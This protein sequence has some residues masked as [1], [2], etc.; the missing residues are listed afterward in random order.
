MM[1]YV[2]GLLLLIA[3]PAMAQ[4]VETPVPFDS[5]G[6]LMALTPE[7]AA[8]LSLGPPAWR[9]VGDYSEARLYSLGAGSYV[10][11]VTRR[12]G[13]VERYSLTEAD[14]QYLFQRT[15][16]LPPSMS[17]ARGERGEFLRDQTILGLAVYAPAFAI[18]ITDDNAG[19]VSAYLLMAGATFFGASQVA[20]DFTIT[21]AMRSL[22]TN[23]ALHGAAAAG[24]LAWAFDG[25]DNAHDNASDD[26]IAAAT[27]VGGI[28][29]TVGGLIAG[30]RMTG[31]EAAASGFGADVA[32]LT[33]LGGIAATQGGEELDEIKRLDAVLLVGAAAVGYPLGYM[34]PRSVSYK[35]TEGDVGTLWVSGLVGASAAGVFLADGNLELRPTAIALTAGFLGG[36]AAGDRLLVRRYDH[37]PGDATMLGLGGIAGGLIGL[38]IA[39][40]I[41]DDEDQN[42][43]LAAGLFTA[44][45][46]GGVGITHNLIAPG[47]DTG[48]FSSR[49]QFNPAGAAFAVAGIEGH[50]SVFSFSF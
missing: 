26:W 10:L 5:A 23:V 12:D 8:R 36:I 2:V 4:V 37:S 24:A 30:N 33:M 28:G 44:G 7:I 14:R 38:G 3:V 48:R 39:N 13:A 40:L 15:S 29:G 22:S 43:R 34:Y 50:H 45:A 49:L 31:G 9:V 21:P 1:R 11:A 6:R 47:R 19:G 20:R 42:D 18:A 25:S 16:T 46:I 35:V 41:D 17:R 27:F 32:A